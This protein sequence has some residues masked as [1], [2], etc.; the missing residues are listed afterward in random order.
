MNSDDRFHLEGKHLYSE[1]LCV[2][3]NMVNNKSQGSDGFT[4]FK[5]FWKKFRLFIVR[6]LNHGYENGKLSCTLKQ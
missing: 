2:L 6:S 1:E 4:G 5:V 3:R